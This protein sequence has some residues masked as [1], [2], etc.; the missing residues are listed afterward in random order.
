MP[1]AY[2]MHASSVLIGTEQGVLIKLLAANC[3]YSYRT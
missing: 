2:N 3:C 1:E